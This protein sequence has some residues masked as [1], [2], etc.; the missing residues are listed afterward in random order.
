MND[1]LIT[2][3]LDSL[4]I[5]KINRPDALNA[6]NTALIDSLIDLFVKEKSNPNCRGVILTGNGGRA[7]VAGADISEMKSMSPLEA[8]N[9]ALKGQQLTNLIEH[10]PKPVIAAVNGFALGGGNE[11]AMAAHI[12]IASENA[13]FG[14]PETGLGLIPGFGGTQRLT[15]L[16]G[17]GRAFEMN[18]SGRIIKADKALQ[19]GLVNEVLPQDELLDYCIK[20]M[21]DILSKGPLA[22]TFTLDSMVRGKDLSLEEALNLEA[23]LFALSFTTED[24]TEGMSAFLEKRKAE[25][26]GK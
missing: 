9:F 5:V 24:K 14:Q 17:A 19:I 25:F 20:L 7:F 15:R 3:Y 16:V 11:L 23:D 12:R 22:T 26:K 1:L 8:R 21:K 2:D 13:K 10:F 6:L 4:L 18:L